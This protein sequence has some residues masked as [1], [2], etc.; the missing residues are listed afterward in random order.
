MRQRERK[1]ILA[2]RTRRSDDSVYGG[3]NEGMKGREEWEKGGTL[4]K[5][6]VGT[7]KRKC[8]EEK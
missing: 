5:R 4:K 8:K 2:K 7:V 6:R 1:I 3:E